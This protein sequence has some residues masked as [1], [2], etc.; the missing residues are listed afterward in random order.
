MGMFRTGNPVLNE[1]TFSQAGTAAAG[2]GMTIQGTAYKTMVLLGIAVCSAAYTWR[3]VMSDAGPAAMPWAIGGAIA[4]IV[5]ALVLRFKMDWAPALAPAYALAEGLFLGAI[6]AVFELRYPGIALQA[7]MATGATLAAL[8]LAYWSRLI[9][10]SENL[11]L[12]IVAAT[13]GIALV[14]LVGMIGSFFGWQIPYIH[15]SGPIGIA[16]SAFV[17][18][19]AALNLVLDFDYIENAAAAGAPKRLEWF[20]AFALLVTLV[21]LY[22]EMLKLL[23]KLR[24]R[25]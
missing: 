24:R 9:K 14:Y 13:G 4:G 17:V 19:V 8:L 11:K 1:R 15:D 18:V 25:D 7:V 6:S 5:I 16:F 10:P 22:I 3:M 12:G 23:A 21:W 20:G 2:A